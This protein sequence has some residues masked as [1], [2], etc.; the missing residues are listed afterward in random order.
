MLKITNLQQL[1][2]LPV[3]T[4]LQK[5]VKAILTEPFYNETENQQAWDELQCELWFLTSFND[6]SSLNPFVLTYLKI[7]KATLD[8]MLV[9]HEIYQYSST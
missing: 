9:T 8:M 5:Q 2:T 4:T 7:T 3:T 6:R 1:S